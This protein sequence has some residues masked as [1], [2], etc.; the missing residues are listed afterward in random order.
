[1]EQPANF[2]ASFCRH[3][4]RPS[5]RSL[6]QKIVKYSVVF[7]TVL[8]LLIPL[9]IQVLA[10]ENENSTENSPELSSELPSAE[11]EQVFDE[12]SE[13][14]A[15]ES[16]ESSK[17]SSKSSKVGKTVIYCRG[18]RAGTYSDKESS[19]VIAYLSRGM[20]ATVLEELGGKYRIKSGKVEGYVKKSYFTTASKEKEKKYKSIIKQATVKKK[21][22]LLYKTKDTEGTV[23]CVLPKGVS[24]K[25]LKK[26][27]KF[28]RIFV[29]GV[30]KGWVETKKVSIKSVHKK[31]VSI[32]E[33]KRIKKKIRAGIRKAKKIEK[34]KKSPKALRKAIVAYARTFVGILPY[35]YGGS[36]LETGVDCSGFTKAI[37]E[38]FG[39]EIPRSSGEQAAG[40]K[41]VSLE[42]AKPGDIVCYAGHVA[43]YIGNNKI[44]HAPVPG[45]YI[46]Y[47]DVNFMPVI[48]VVRY[49]P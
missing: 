18:K 17:S 38:K 23:K 39:I 8:F 21:K 49:I 9:N 29:P 16:L 22:T 1:M 14:N 10:L 26:G 40:G 6:K 31:A 15:D 13:E 43:L 37:Y 41:S 30:G 4:S 32:S 12:N 47:A 36:D 46:S 35:V 45:E 11:E 3:V 19:R 33:N 2:K 7:F 5:E 48:G 44:I 25:V 20:E 24:F 34:E 27:K 28:T 42:N